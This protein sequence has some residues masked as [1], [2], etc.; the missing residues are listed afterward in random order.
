MTDT[1][2]TT[3][4]GFAAFGKPVPWERKSAALAHVRE[5]A[6][7]CT[8]EAAVQLIDR[9]SRCIERDDPYAA[10]RHAS[11]AEWAV[12]ESKL[13]ESADVARS[14]DPDQMLVLD[15]TGAYRLLAALCT[16]PAA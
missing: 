13:Q 15:V 5:M 12:H 6:P 2:V 14:L 9:V 4:D 16:D 1:T 8:T 11:H 10:L 7:G 3:D